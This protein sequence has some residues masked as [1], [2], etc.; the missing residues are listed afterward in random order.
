MK[1]ANKQLQIR[2]LKSAFLVN[3]YIKG[4]R[5]Y[6][7]EDYLLEFI[8]NSKFYIEHG[9][10]KFDAIVK[11]DKGEP[12]AK[13]GKYEIDFKIFAEEENI[14]AKSELGEQIWIPSDGLTCYGVKQSKYKEIG[15]FNLCK[16]FRNR[17]ENETDDNHKKQR[18]K[19]LETAYKILETKKNIFI[20][21]PFEFLFME[22]INTN[23]MIKIIIDELEE[24]LKNMMKCR[25]NK[26][27]KDM[28]VSFIADKLFVII[29]CCKAEPILYDAVSIENSELFYKIYEL[30]KPF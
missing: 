9:N 26:T 19:A 15:Y 29:D 22:N 11:Q 27:D 10:K 8:N 7:Y 14:H 2:G 6:K 5:K 1:T 16:L 21:L 28:F 20:M 3:N 4:F 18:K 30:S 23:D 12:D 13:N 25:K 24:D 17:E